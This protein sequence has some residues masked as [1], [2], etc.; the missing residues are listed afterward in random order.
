MPFPLAEFVLRGSGLVPDFRVFQFDAVA[1]LSILT[2]YLQQITTS[3]KHRHF[4]ETP[5][6]L[7]TTRRMIFWS[8]PGPVL[9]VQEEVDKHTGQPGATARRWGCCARSRW[10]LQGLLRPLLPRN[11]TREPVLC[12]V[13]TLPG[14]AAS[15][16]TGRFS[17]LSQLKRAKKLFL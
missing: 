9:E 13:A 15:C 16:G 3:W 12:T 1:N 11:W 5:T 17:K 6:F 10:R 14:A 7:L 8:E 4:L 2:K